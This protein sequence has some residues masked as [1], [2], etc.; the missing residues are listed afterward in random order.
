MRAMEPIPISAAKTIAE[1]YGYHQ[2]VIVARRV[3]D[4]EDGGEDG[5]EHVTTY[6]V[7][8]ANC[9]IAARIGGAP[10]PQAH[11]DDYCEGGMTVN[12]E[13]NVHPDDA[14]RLG[15]R[16]RGLV[17][18]DAESV[19]VAFTPAGQQGIVVLRIRHAT[20]RELFYDHI[21][22]TAPNIVA[23]AALSQWAA[24]GRPMIG[25]DVDLESWAVSEL[26]RRDV[27]DV[28]PELARAAAALDAHGDAIH[29][30]GSPA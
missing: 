30:K 23:N 13:F 27:S 16:P 4:G 11:A 5:G 7:D 25:S 2:V 22:H 6:G 18:V 20:R 17:R 26:H 9:A 15:V 3:G 14:N 28:E 24:N 1:A 12:A 10:G 19:R 8:K 29:S 21:V